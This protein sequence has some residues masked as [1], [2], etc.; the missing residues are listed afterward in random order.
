MNRAELEARVAELEANEAQR[1]A[2]YIQQLE[3][4]VAD[5]QDQIARWRSE[6]Y[7][8]D[9]VAKMAVEKAESSLKLVEAR[10]EGIANARRNRAGISGLN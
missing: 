9:Q 7:R 1:Q 5:L 4:T 2:V 10:N 3:A 6:A 8:L